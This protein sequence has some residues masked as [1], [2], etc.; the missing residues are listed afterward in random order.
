MFSDLLVIER[1]FVW[2]CVWMCCVCVGGCGCVRERERERETERVRAKLKVSERVHQRFLRRI[3]QSLPNF[4]V[5]D[6]DSNFFSQLGFPI[7]VAAASS[8]VD[9]S[10]RRAGKV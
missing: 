9:S 8:R 1:Y 6:S 7:F 3:N 5:E 2:F 4:E 10:N